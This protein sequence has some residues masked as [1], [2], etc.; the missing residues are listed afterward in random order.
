MSELYESIDELD[1]FPF[2]SAT[3]PADQVNDPTRGT[4]LEWV[5]DY[6]WIYVLLLLF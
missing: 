4:E 2:D 5:C 1:E 3:E 6:K